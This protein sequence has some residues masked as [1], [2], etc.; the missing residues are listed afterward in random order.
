MLLRNAANTGFTQDAGSPSRSA[1][2]RSG[3][4]RRLRPRRRPGHR[5]R[6]QRRRRRHPPARRRRLR[7]RR[8]D[9]RDRRPDGV[10]VADFD[11]DSRP[12]PRCRRSASPNRHGPAQPVARRAAAAPRPRPRPT[13]TPTASAGRAVKDR[14]RRAGLGQGAGSSSRAASRYVDLGGQANPGRDERSTRAT[15]ASRSR[16]RPE[17]QE[18]RGRLLRRAVQ[19]RPDQGSAGHDAHADRGAELPERQEGERRGQEAEDAQAVGRRQGQVPHPRAVQRRH[20]PRHPV[21]HAG[22]LR[23]DASR[24][25]QGVGRRPRRG[26]EARP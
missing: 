3:R 2:A 8:A 14:Q 18:P 6:R 9:H 25:K 7:A 24:V 10:A 15:A 20:R 4:G 13:P 23:L 5:R 12:D 17:R 16:P 11:G 26:Q 22:P 19:A 21:A 1:T